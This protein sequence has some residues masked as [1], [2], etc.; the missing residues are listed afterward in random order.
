MD[1]DGL[2]E[3]RPKEPNT[4]H[5]DDMPSPLDERKGEKTY[6]RTPDGTSKFSI[7]CLVIECFKAC[8]SLASRA[9]P[10]RARI[11][12]KACVTSKTNSR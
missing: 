7:F 1:G 10:L 6:G 3:R 11:E 9:R 4:D 8:L 2:R 12:S 5:D